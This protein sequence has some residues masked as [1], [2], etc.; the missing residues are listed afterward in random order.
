[1]TENRKKL[2]TLWWSIGILLVIIIKSFIPISSSNQSSGP[3]GTYKWIGA[4]YPLNEG[5]TRVDRVYM[6]ENEFIELNKDGSC[7]F[8]SQ[9]I[10]HHDLESTGTCEYIKDENKFIC[11]WDDANSPWTIQLEK[12][13]YGY[14][15]T[16]GNFIYAK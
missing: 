16:L 6:T 1:M 14:R 10:D 9:D 8:H 12:D 7:L 2:K 5:I 15:F 11:H 4:T 13:R 3:F